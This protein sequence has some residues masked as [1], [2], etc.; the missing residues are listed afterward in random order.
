M[1]VNSKRLLN[2]TKIEI[3]TFVMANKDDCAQRDI[4]DK[5]SIWKILAL[6]EGTV[7]WNV[8]WPEHSPVFTYETHVSNKVEKNLSILSMYRKH[9]AIHWEI[10]YLGI[11]IFSWFGVLMSRCIVTEEAENQR[12]QCL[13]GTKAYRLCQSIQIVWWRV[14]ATCRKKKHKSY[15]GNNRKYYVPRNKSY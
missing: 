7:C 13:S 8:C 1:A 10:T 4:D 6:S 5:G 15:I 11:F 12:A 14:C 2:W 3:V 9:L